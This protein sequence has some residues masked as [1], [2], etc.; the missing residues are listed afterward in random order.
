MPDG[1]RSSDCC[2]RVCCMTRMVVDHPIKTITQIQDWEFMQG[3]PYFCKK[4][5]RMTTGEKEEI[6]VH[7]RKEIANLEKSVE[8]IT[9]LLDDDVQADANDWFTTKESNPSKEINEMA[10]EKARK[11]IITLR[12]VLN[13]IDSPDFGICSVCGKDIPAGRI[14]IVPNA[15]RCTNCG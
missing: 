7:I 6:R 2:K 3:F 15:S 4:L 14:K 5:V 10:L 12:E 1:R 13:R 8:T 11:K 9:D